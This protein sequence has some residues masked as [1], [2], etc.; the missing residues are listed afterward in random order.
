MEVCYDLV[1]QSQLIDLP[2][3]GRTFTWYRPNGKCKSRLVNYV[4]LD[5]WA[6]IILNELSKTIFDHFPILKD[7]GPSKPFKLFNSWLLTQI[8]KRSL[9]PNGSTMTSMVGGVYLKEKLKVFKMYVEEWKGDVF[10][11]I[12]DVFG[13][14]PE[15][16]VNRK[17]RFAELYRALIWKEDFLYQKAKSKWLNEGDTNTKFFH[18]WITRRHKLLNIE[19]LHLNNVWLIC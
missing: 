4:W 17:R 10:G 15:E 1:N 6:G 7:W 19:G 14:E 8:S 11:K 9:I 12:D 18:S 2:L 3:I 5:K 16:V 13:L